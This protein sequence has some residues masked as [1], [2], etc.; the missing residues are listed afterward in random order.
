MNT[1]RRLRITLG[2]ASMLVGQLDYIQ[3]GQREHSLFAY[4]PDWLQAHDGFNV[5]PDLAWQV[6]REVVHSLD[7]WR[8]VATSAEVGM[9]PRDV[10]DFAPAFDHAQMYRARQLGQAVQIGLT[11]ALR[12]KVLAPTR[13]HLDHPSHLGRGLGRRQAK[14]RRSGHR[15]GQCGCTHLIAHDELLMPLPQVG[16]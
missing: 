15:V 5:S 14:I 2:Q 11:H 3:Q 16:R 12:R 7:S 4:A 9:S 8:E 10:E 13:H 1:Q 6:L